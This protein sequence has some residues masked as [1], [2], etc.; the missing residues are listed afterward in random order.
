MLTN[1]Q[2]IMIKNNI[3]TKIETKNGYIRTDGIKHKTIY[4]L[5]IMQR[6]NNSRTKLTKLCKES[7]KIQFASQFD[8]SQHHL[9]GVLI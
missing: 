7:I 9:C 8:R 4:R 1:I 2:N 5:Y 6:P 3:S